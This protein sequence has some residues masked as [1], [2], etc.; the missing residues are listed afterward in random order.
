MESNK[1]NFKVSFLESENFT[2]FRYITILFSLTI[3][4]RMFFL[5]HNSFAV[6]FDG[7]YYALQ[8]RSL[9]ETGQLLIADNSL[10]FQILRFFAM[11]FQDVVL[12]NKIACLLFG[13]LNVIILYLLLIKL[14]INKWFAFLC[15]ILFLSSY[16]QNFLGFELQKNNIS[17]TFFLTFLLFFYTSLDNKRYIIYTFLFFVLTLLTHK[18][19][20][21]LAMLFLIIYFI[22]ILI[23]NETIRKKITANKK[24]LLL[25]CSSFLIIIII[26]F[27]LSPLRLVDLKNLLSSFTLYS[28]LVNRFKKIIFIRNIGTMIE[29]ILLHVIPFLF[30]PFLKTYIKNSKNSKQQ[31]YFATALLTFSIILIFPFLK[32]DWDSIAFRFLIINTI[33]CCIFIGY[34]ASI[35]KNRL[36]TTSK[37]SLIIISI[38]L[39]SQIPSKIKTF[40]TRRYPNYKDLYSSMLRI[41]DYVPE[42]KKIIAHKGLSSFIWYITGIEGTHFTPI[43]NLEDYYRIV[44]G[45]GVIHFEPYLE[46]GDYGKPVEIKMP[47]FLVEEKL[48]QKFYND[49]KDKVDFLKEWVNPSQVRPEHVYH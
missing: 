36:K 5:L 12:S 45:F 14:R 15:G 16:T 10:V 44:Y 24:L 20:G 28:G 23:Y 13:A 33:P 42:G 22:I 37:I 43:E 30:I 7:Y 35:S 40:H 38:L 32:F 46:S 31:K 8:V 18:L 27:F 6:G 19:M 2:L 9:K 29:L 11:F 4:I 21:A 34:M 48:W 49:K 3:L 1:Q 41:K 39:M 17:M 26:I 25:T 47:Y